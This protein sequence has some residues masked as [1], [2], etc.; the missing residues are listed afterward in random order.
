MPRRIFP[1]LVLVLAL[2]TLTG[3]TACAGDR[4]SH[5][6]LHGSLPWNGDLETGDLSQFKD[7][8]WNVAG[9]AL[10]PIAVSDPAVVR[11]G[12][13]AVAMTIPG[14]WKGGGICCGTRSELEPNI[15][16]IHPGDDLYFSFSTMLG[17]G[18][19]TYANWQTITQW[20]NN[21]DGSP[22]LE[23]DVAYGKYKVSGGFAH[24]YGAEP[25][26]KTIGPAVT[27][28]WVDWAFHIKFSPDPN[29]GYVEI[30]QGGKLVLPRF[31]PASGTMYPNPHG[32]PM[33]YLKTGY[34]RDRS[35]EAAGTIYF[36]NWKVDTARDVVG[37][38]WS[39]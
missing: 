19:P 8:P 14:T 7:T 34:Y 9:G 35:I 5:E 13:Y 4:K 36:D 30:W 31:Q 20:K 22:P 11:A 3:L 37:H 12:K 21:F 38:Q 2:I 17:E 16:D 23:L 10:P 1:R 39:R 18:F 15:P 29:V 28:Q 26:R 32:E 27:G 6:P 24:P 25:F 33:S